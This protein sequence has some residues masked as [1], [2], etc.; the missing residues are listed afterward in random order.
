MFMPVNTRTFLEKIEALPAE[1]IAEVETFVALLRERERTLA[2]G[3]A[4]P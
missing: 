4:W 2:R 3:A 1:R